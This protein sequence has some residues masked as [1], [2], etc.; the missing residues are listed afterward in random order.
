MKIT[1]KS[2]WVGLGFLVSGVCL[3][4]FLR[5]MEW[6]RVGVALREAKYF[7]VLPCLL[8]FILGYVLRVIRWRSLIHE[9]KRVSFL[10]VFSATSIGFM[11]NHLLPARAG[12]IVRTVLLGKKEDIGMATVFAT[13]VMERLLDSMSLIILAVVIFALIPSLH[14]SAGMDPVPQGVMEIQDS[15]FLLQLKSGVGVLGATCLVSLL[16]FIFLDLYTK[17]SLD[18]VRR[19][20]FF[21]PHNLREKLI[22]ILESFVLGLKVVKSVRQ[23]IWL[24]AL[25]FGIWFLFI[26]GVY[27]LGYSFG[28]KIP[29]TGM[30]VVVVCTG[31]AV[32]LPQAPGYIGVYHLAVLKSLELF[33]VEPSVAQSFAI[34]LWTLNLFLTLILGGFFLWREGMGLGQL[35]VREPVSP[36]GPKG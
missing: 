27:I 4:L 2:V 13:I 14:S 8:W 28:I 29:Y 6:D 5:N 33:H 22:N 32:A 11:A 20:L 31:L 26:T 30:C 23:V 35:L 34:V 16:F 3:W 15:H 12:E 25:S 17:Q 24:S 18:L 1:G 21:L 19:L 36:A 9:V 10:N 7:Y